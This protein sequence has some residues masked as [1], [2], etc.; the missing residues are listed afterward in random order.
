M[1]DVLIEMRNLTRIFRR[2]A[3]QVV[4]LQDINLDI[5]EKDFISLMGPSGSGKSTLL[6]LIAGI[7]RPTGGQLQV[8][9]EDLT[10][11][12]EDQLAAWRNE[13]VGFVFQH[14]NLIPVLTAFEN[15]ELP[16]L[17]TSLSRQERR[18][19]VETALRLVNLSDRIH[20]YPRQLSGGEEQRVAIARAIVTDPT[21]ILAD[22]PTGDLDAESAGDIL[23]VLEALNRDFGKTIVM[24][25]HDPRAA[26]FA[27]INHHLEKGSLLAKAPGHDGSSSD[28]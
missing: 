11:L 3:V 1:T 12:N 26:A 8:L 4:A 22:E 14:F 28:V 13:H 7:D 18:E 9:G 24:V 16:L 6:N 20:H 5:R 17:L 25:T 2:D 21:F 15:V 27:G 19:H 23:K 10:A